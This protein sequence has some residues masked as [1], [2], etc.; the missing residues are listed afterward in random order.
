MTRTSKVFRLVA[1]IG[2]VW[3]TA[4]AEFPMD[5]V[6]WLLGEAGCC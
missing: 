3:L 2:M 4:A 5:L 1:I 6:M